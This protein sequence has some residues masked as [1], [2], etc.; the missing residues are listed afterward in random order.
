VVI[1]ENICILVTL[2]RLSSWLL[3]AIRKSYVDTYMNIATI[4][5][6]RGWEF[7]RQQGRICRRKGKGK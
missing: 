6:K 4:N 7:E 2:Y 5:E 1:P 3:G